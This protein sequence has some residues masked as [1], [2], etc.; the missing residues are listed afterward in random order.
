MINLQQVAVCAAT[1][2]GS[3]PLP[4]SASAQ[5]EGGAVPKATD[6]RAARPVLRVLHG[7]PTPAELAALVAVLAAGAAAPS[8]HGVGSESVRSAW[9]G[10][11]RYLRTTLRPGPGAW[12]ASAW[13]H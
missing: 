13:P 2:T 4:Y 11:A 7:D 8:R 10:R 5:P 9:Q 1:T 12:R 6:D 3:D